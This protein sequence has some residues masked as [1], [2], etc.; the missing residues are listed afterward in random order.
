MTL[1]GIAVPFSMFV[2]LLQQQIGRTVVDMTGLDGLYDFE[3]TFSS[4]GLQSPFARGPLAPA[5]SAVA[6]GASAL[7]AAADPVPSLFASIQQLGLKLESTKGPAEVLVI[8]S[9][10]KPTEN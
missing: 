5:P 4:E 9:V 3:L 8:D 10:Q 7:P 2:R 1:H 6:A